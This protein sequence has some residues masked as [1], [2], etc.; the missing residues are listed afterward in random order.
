MAHTD[1]N[2]PLVSDL[3]PGELQVIW[4]AGLLKQ[5]ID[6]LGIQPNE[7]PSYYNRFKS[8]YASGTAGYWYL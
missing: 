4:Y 7:Y 3:T 1:D 5:L 2:G 6:S 8:E